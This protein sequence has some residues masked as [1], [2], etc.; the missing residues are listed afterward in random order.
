MAKLVCTVT[1]QR[2]FSRAAARLTEAAQAEVGARNLIA[3]R[4]VI[5]AIGRGDF[6]AALRDAELDVALEIFA[7]PEFPWIR[8]AIGVDGLRAAIQHN[9]SSVLDQQPEI[10]TITTDGDTVVILGRE[11]GRMRDT[12]DAYAMEFVQRF[13]FR[14]GRLASVKIIAARALDE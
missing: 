12:G 11:R 5:E 7:P 2:D 13:Q 3:I 8:R 6:D 14:A 9:F 10:T 4:D 1:T